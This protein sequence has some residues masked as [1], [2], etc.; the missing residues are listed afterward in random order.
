MLT[1][2]YAPTALISERV[3][4]PVVH[5]AEYDYSKIATICERNA[6][7]KIDVP[8]QALAKGESAGDLSSN[9]SYPTELSRDRC[10]KLRAF[11]YSQTPYIEQSK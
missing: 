9:K 8:E 4:D 11:R 5:I 1:H 3:A 2:R 6:S 7:A 10:Q